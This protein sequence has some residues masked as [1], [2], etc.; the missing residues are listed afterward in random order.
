MRRNKYHIFSSFH[1]SKV[2]QVLRARVRRQ[3]RAGAHAYFTHVQHTT[4]ACIQRA[5]AAETG[6]QFYSFSYACDGTSRVTAADT[7]WNSM[8]FIETI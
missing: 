1:L 5:G 7:S 6:M 4:R 2:I 8:K 3:G